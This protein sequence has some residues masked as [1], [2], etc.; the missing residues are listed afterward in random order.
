MASA[1]RPSEATVL[2]KLR[3]ICL[4]LPDAYEEPAWV[5]TRWMI[6]KR[7]F[8]HVVPIAAGKPAAYAAAAGSDGPLLVL[9]FRASALLRDT[10]RYA[11]ERFFVPVWG[12]KWGTKVVGL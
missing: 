5:G 4:Q 9:T 3:A 11:G 2:K 8:A 6:R 10:L 12:T 1:R 7:N